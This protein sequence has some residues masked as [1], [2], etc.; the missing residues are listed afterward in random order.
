MWPYFLVTGIIVFAAILYPRQHPNRLAWAA[1][2]VMLVL[3]TGLRHK[4]GMDWNNYLYMGQYF[5]AGSLLNAMRRAEPAYGLLLWTSMKAGFGVYG[6]NL[7]GA[8]VFC[9]GLFRCARATSA[10]WLALAV[11]MPMLVIVVSMSANR[12]TIAIGVLLWLVAAWPQLSLWK[13]VFITLLASTFHFSAIFFLMFSALD[14]RLKPTYKILLSVSMMVAIVVFMQYSGAFDTYDQ[15]YVGGQTSATYSPGATQH[16]LFNGLPAILAMVMVRFTNRLLP[17]AL[18]RHMAI[19][20]AALVPLAFFYSTA[21]G[22]MTMYMFPVSMFVF[23]GF[24][25]SLKGGNARA[26]GRTVLGFLMAGVLAYWLAYSNSSH[27]YIP[28]SNALLMR[29]EKLAL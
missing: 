4:V 17:I 5:K 28:Y 11:A 25:Q 23:T 9:L 14:M 19:F 29:A 20:S 22:R 18:L 27:A 12:Q 8:I 16:V 26:M 24:I 6:A 15:S 7:I 13:R 2:F 10:P 21:A 1:A 3:F